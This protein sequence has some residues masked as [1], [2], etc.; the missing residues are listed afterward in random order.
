MDY[1]L[2]LQFKNNSCLDLDM[3][4]ELEDDLRQLVM[5]MAEVDGHDIGAGEMNIFVLTDDPVG[6]FE[7]AKP[8]LAD[9]SLL[10]EVAVAYRYLRSDDFIVIWPEDSPDG[11]LVS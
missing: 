8:L 6:T 4:V 1:Q 5:S 3:L 7:R 11:F 9:S 2:V 10:H